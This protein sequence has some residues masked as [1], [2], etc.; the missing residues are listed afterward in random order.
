MYY[1]LTIPRVRKN[2]TG[3]TCPY[4]QTNNDRFRKKLLTNSLTLHRKEKNTSSLNKCL[5]YQ[6]RKNVFLHLCFRLLHVV[7]PASP[8]TIGFARY[9]IHADRWTVVV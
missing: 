2:E 5:F 7:C 1:A 4:L 6:K 8:Q 9:E 3:R